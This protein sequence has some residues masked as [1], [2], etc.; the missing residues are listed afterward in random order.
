MNQYAEAMIAFENAQLGKPYVFGKR[1]PN[2]FDC[3]GLQ[4]GGARAAGLDSTVFPNSWT[5]RNLTAWARKNNYLRLASSGYVPGPGDLGLWGPADGGQPIKGA[6]HVILVKRAPTA[7]RPNGKAISAFNP[8][9]G[10]INHGIAP[11][12]GSHLA[13]YG[14]IV[15]PYPQ[16]EMPAEIED[17]APPDDAVEPV[18][19]DDAPDPAAAEIAD[20]KEQLAVAEQAA[21]DA[22]FDA[23]VAEAK[24]VEA[25][26]HGRAIA[27]L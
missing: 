10:V 11:K 25:R 9:K 16:F 6:G 18:E 14:F 7:A 15:L 22:T 5:V 20:L 8:N 19:D 17:S 27:A 1:G 26:Q 3:M 24:L 13:L 12:A 4:H 23:A 21:K 2:A